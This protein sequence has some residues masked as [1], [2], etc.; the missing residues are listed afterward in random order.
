MSRSPPLFS[1]LLVDRGSCCPV[2]ISWHSWVTFHEIA[3]F[4]LCAP[5]I[6][7][8]L[9]VLWSNVCNHRWEN[10]PFRLLISHYIGFKGESFYPSS[11]PHRPS[12]WEEMGGAAL[13]HPFLY[14]QVALLVLFDLNT[15]QMNAQY[16]HMAICSNLVSLTI[17]RS[18]PS[19]KKGS[20]P[21]ICCS[22]TPFGLVCSLFAFQWP[23]VSVRTMA[24]VSLMSCPLIRRQ[25]MREVPRPC[26]IRAGWRMEQT[27]T[28]CWFTHTNA[29]TLQHW[30]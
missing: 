18:A 22:S 28:G 20:W 11:Y 7:F 30:Y 1:S 16:A 17:N 8:P 24:R 2:L 27:Q 29:H 4:S 12:S 9:A 5:L 6:H 3:S 10:D 26:G 23:T 21:N 25:Q 19:V 15:V 13:V 14:L